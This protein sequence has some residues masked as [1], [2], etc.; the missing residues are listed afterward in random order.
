MTPIVNFFFDPFQSKLKISVHIIPKYFRMYV[1]NY[2]LEFSV[3]MQFFFCGG[4][5]LHAMKCMRV[6]FVLT[7]LNPLYVVQVYDYVFVYP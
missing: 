1:T 6:L 4:N 7:H 3:Y 5:L 2:Q